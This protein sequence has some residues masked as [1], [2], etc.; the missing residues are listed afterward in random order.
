MRA[1]IQRVKQAEVTINDEI[2]AKI[3]QGFLVL[4]GVGVEDTKKEADL[5]WRKISGMRIFADAEGKTNLDL[6]A[7]D[8]NLL[9]I[10]QFTLYANCKKGNRPS[11]TDAASPKKGEELYKYFLELAKQDFPDLEQGEFGANMSVNLIND[12]PFTIYLDSDDL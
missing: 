4:L 10:S 12:G 1:I 2:S 6:K 11:F 7:V 5:L 3:K 9:I 8:G